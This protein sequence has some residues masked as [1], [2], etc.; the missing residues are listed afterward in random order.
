MGVYTRAGSPWY[1]L[2]LERAGTRGLKERTRIRH[3]AP[4]AAERKRARELAEDAYRVRMSELARGTY[5]LPGARPSITFAA[6]ADWYAAHVSAHQAGAHRE[7]EI[8]KQ[9]RAA[10]AGEALTDLTRDRVREWMTARVAVVSASTVNRELDLLKSMLRE[11]VPT[12]LAASPLVGLRRLTAKR[13]TGTDAGDDALRIL[14]CDEEWRLYKALPDPRDVVLVM[15]ALDTLAR[16][17]SLLA[18]TWTDDRRSHLRFRRPKNGR[19]YTV[20]VSRRLRAALDALPHAGPFIFGH[21]RT[22]T[23]PALW[24]S[25]VKN[26]LAR[27]CQRAGVAY[28][29]TA[30]GI[31]FH[32]LRHTGASRMIA[33]GVDLRTVQDLGGWSDVRLLMRY[34]HPTTAAKQRAV[35]AVGGE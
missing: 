33:R 29:R 12:Y 3:D 14:T 25:I 20:P 32:S 1:W 28:G 7:A 34:V 15:A 35:E 11:A 6:F 2:Y 10:F 5:E 4:T 17:S 31:T 21:R 26:L 9:L 16:L 13:A 19:T 22:A 24:R 30:G 23:T 27:A 8:L 18:L